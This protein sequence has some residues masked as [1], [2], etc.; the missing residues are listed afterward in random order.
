[1]PRILVNKK[2]FISKI[3]LFDVDG[4]L[5]DDT[6]RYKNL[7]KARFTN[8]MKFSSRKATEEWARLTGI[9]L[10]TGM[11]D[12]KGPISK[13]SRRDDL[14]IAAGALYLDG[15]NWYKARKMAEMIYEKADETLLRSYEPV[16]YE[17]VK[18]KLQELQRAGFKIGIATNGVTKIT[19]DLLS[20]LGIKQLFTVVVGADLVENNKPEPDII[21]LACK[22]GGFDISEVAYVGDQPID[23][24]AAK[25][26]GVPIIFIIGNKTILNESVEKIN[27]VQDI[28]IISES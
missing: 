16:L 18:E 19:E 27:S 15:H 23:V 20:K 5:I 1:M 22:I 13:A 6:H 14:A 9:N 2:A 11:I 26:A 3:L 10:V 8:F 25:K 21:L 17:G 28:E 7:A 4:T 12:P 24:I